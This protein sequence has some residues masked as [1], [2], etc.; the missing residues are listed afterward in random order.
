M[1]P[2]LVARVKLAEGTGPMKDG[3]HQKYA[4]HL[5]VSTIGFGFNLEAHRLPAGMDADKGITRAQAERLL[6]LKLQDAINDARTFAWFASLDEARQD[7]VVEM[8]YQM[9]LTRFR[10]FGRCIA[11]L[12]AGHYAQ[13]SAEILNSRWARVQTPGRAQRIAA[14]I[15]TGEPQ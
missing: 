7:A 11:A 3:R 14:T 15:R 2:D 1:T 5:G 8:L 10:G 6:L 9:G 4:D 12:K 13:A